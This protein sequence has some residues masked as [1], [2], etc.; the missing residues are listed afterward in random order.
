MMKFSNGSIQLLIILWKELSFV[1]ES[2]FNFFF[3]LLLYTIFMIDVV[4]RKGGTR[5]KLPWGLI[6]KIFHQHNTNKKYSTKY[7]VKT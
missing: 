1:L 7:T 2:G 6:Y 3:R 5:I 4:V